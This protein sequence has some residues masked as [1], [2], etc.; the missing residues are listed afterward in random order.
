MG[1][2]GLGRLGVRNDVA[3]VGEEKRWKGNDCHA[4][5]AGCYYHR[6]GTLRDNDLQH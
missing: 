4:T 3:V 1:R 5:V 2:R 6:Y